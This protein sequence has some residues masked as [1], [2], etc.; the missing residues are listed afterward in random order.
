MGELRIDIFEFT[1]R[2]GNDN[3]NRT[4]LD[5]TGELA[6]IY[7]AKFANRNL[8]IKAAL[9]L[10]Q[11]LRPTGH[12]FIEASHHTK[13]FFGGITHETVGLLQCFFLRKSRLD[14]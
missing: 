6:Q 14:G 1:L 11:S 13:D 8:L 5:C 10:K 3:R 4:V 7:F 9:A 2:I 12:V